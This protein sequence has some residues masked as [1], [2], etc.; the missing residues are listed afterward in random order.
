MDEE[1][2]KRL[3]HDLDANVRIGKKGITTSI[4]EEIDRQLENDDLVKV[5]VLR[6]N[7]LQDIDETKKILE[8]LTQ[9]RVI[10]I[11]GSTILLYSD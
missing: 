3:G 11:R 7:P 5:K 8:D 2:A 1:E 9:G 10:E 4:V 6:N